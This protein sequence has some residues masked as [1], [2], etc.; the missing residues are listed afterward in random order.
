MDHPVARQPQ[1]LIG[2]GQPG[3]KGVGQRGVDLVAHPMDGIDIG[4]LEQLGQG[5]LT[6]QRQDLRLEGQVQL[7]FVQNGDKGRQ[8][9]W[10]ELNPLPLLHPCHPIDDR[11]V[12]QHLGRIPAGKLVAG[13]AHQEGQRLIAVVIV[14]L[15]RGGEVPQQGD[16]RLDRHSIEDE[17]LLCFQHVEHVADGLAL[18]LQRNGGTLLV[19]ELDVEGD[20]QRQFLRLILGRRGV[21][22]HVEAIDAAGGIVVVGHGQ[23]GGAGLAVP[24]TETAEIHAGSILHRL[25]EV[26]AGG[27]RAVVTLEVEAHAGLEIILTQQGVQH[28]DHFRAL[29]VDGQGV[30]VVHL[31]H[32]IRADGV[33]HGAGIFGKLRTAHCAHV[34]DAVDPT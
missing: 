33:G 21:L 20:V 23:L 27:G 26:I 22:A 14:Q 9:G 31:D 24:A 7:G 29:L 28:A 32:H 13:K 6:G 11:L 12:D 34:V 15:D 5:R 17:G 30:E 4:H 8:Q 16:D 2:V 10:G 19:I 3:T 25:H 18:V 1:T